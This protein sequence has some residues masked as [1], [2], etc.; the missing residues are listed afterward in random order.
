MSAAVNDY[1]VHRVESRSGAS[2]L[3]H[4]PGTKI[5]SGAEELVIRLRRSGKVIDR[6]RDWGLLGPIVGFKYEAR[7]TLLASARSLLER[8]GAALVAAN[9]LC[10]RVQ[11]LVD[12]NG[13]ETAP[14][15]ELLLERLVERLE[16]LSVT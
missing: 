4:E 5:A 11:A 9:S 6:L 15:R 3:A 2:F 7:E 1:E 8:A 10:G 16:R 12:G 13:V 14:S